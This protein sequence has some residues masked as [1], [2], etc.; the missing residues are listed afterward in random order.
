MYIHYNIN[1]FGNNTGDCVI[2]AISLALG[3]NWFMV[4]DELSFLSRKMGDM[5]SSNRVWKTY[6]NRLGLI[7]EM[8]E[9][10]CPRCLTVEDFCR[11]HPYGRFI[12]ST[13][14]Y[15]KAN[16]ILP[17]GTH[18]IAVINGDYYDTWDSGLDIPLSYFV[19]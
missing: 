5:P 2:R 13:C 3:Y 18:V 11:S 15:S 19:V 7:E 6:L 1:P 12:L 9:T 8:V 4:H 10:K 14:E 17:S 16:D